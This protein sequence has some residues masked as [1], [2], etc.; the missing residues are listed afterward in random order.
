[1]NYIVTGLRRCNKYLLMMHSILRPD[2]F[3]MIPSSPV[4]FYSEFSFTEN[5][6]SQGLE[7]NALYM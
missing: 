6:S 7:K 3:Q 5:V 2:A 4:T 1:M